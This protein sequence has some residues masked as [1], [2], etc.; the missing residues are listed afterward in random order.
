M[1]LNQLKDDLEQGEDVKV[2][3]DG[4]LVTAG[5]PQQGTSVKPNT[6]AK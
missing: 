5:A 4:R 6:W 3:P 2:A 1:D